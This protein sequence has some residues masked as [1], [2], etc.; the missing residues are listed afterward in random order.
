[1]VDGMRLRR[2]L[3]LFAAL[4]PFSFAFDTPA[5]FPLPPLTLQPQ[6]PD[7]HI[8]NLTS[9]LPPASITRATPIPLPP[10][11]AAY[12]GPDAECTADMV[13]LNVTFEDCGDAFTVCRCA[14]AEMSTDTVLDRFG[15]VPVGL[16]RYAGTVVVL[17]NPNSHAYTLTIGGSHFF[18]DCEMDTWVHE[19]THA[20]D[21]IHEPPLSNSSKWAAALAADT[22][23]PDEYSLTNAVEDFAQVGVIKIYML[24]HSGVL[25]LFFSADCMANQL[26]FLDAL[27]L[28]DPEPLFGN[29]CNI[30]G[31]G[32]PARH[33]TPP[34]TLDP[35]RTFHTVALDSMTFAAAET[36][37]PNIMLVACVL[38]S[39]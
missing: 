8:F 32:P 25:P 19:M 18:G 36:G 34:A 24:L 10:S 21:F 13:A 33:N 22:C 6:E 5:E 26:A 15:R 2:R 17:S 11:C 1:M 16:R 30:T 4:A 31:V 3:I 12:V 39:C 37:L 7:F 35:A 23:V 14:D 9:D 29:S 27:K 20:F 38:V 28:Y